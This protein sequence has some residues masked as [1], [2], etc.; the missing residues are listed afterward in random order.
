MEHGSELWKFLSSRDDVTD[1]PETPRE[2][3]TIYANRGTHPLWLL[4]GAKARV[5]LTDHKNQL[6][7][8]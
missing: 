6:A 2:T 7:R 5:A 4:R 1:A 8:A 3:A